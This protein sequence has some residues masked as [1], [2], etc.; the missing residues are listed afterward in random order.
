[1]HGEFS[2]ALLNRSRTRLAPTPTNISTKSDPEI[3]KNGTSASP[4]IALASSVL[5][6]PGSPMSSTPRGIRPPSLVN[7]LGFLRN[8]MISVTS[9][10]ASS[11][12]ATSLKVTPV[13]SLVSMRCRLLPKLPSMPPGP[14]PAFRS[15]RET[16]NQ[17]SAKSSRNGPKVRM[18][19]VR[20]DGCL[21]LALFPV[22]S[23]TCVV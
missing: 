18:N 3:E 15:P 4:A 22:I 6:Q 21:A 2:L 11:M 14:P 1:M 10:L 5:P 13:I 20:L 16:K 9:S 12:P 8:S 7:F 23:I 17:I 19:G